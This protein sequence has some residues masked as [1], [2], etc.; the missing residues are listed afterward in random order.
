M[1]NKK[2]N[3]ILI[4]FII[5]LTSFILWIFFTLFLDNILENTMLKTK[6]Y[7][8]ETNLKEQE[9][10]N[11]SKYDKVYNII[12][13]YYY[14]ND[15]L[16]DDDLINWSINWLVDW[17]WDKHSD[18]LTPEEY[19]QFNDNLSWDFE[20]IGA[21]IEINPLW[22]EVDRILKGSPAKKNDLRSWDIIIKANEIE[23]TWMSLLEAVNNIKWPKW[24]NVEL[25]ILREWV[26]D[27]ITKNVTRDQIKIPSI[28]YELLD[29]NIGYVSINTFWEETFVDFQSALLELKDTNWLV[30]DLRDNWGWFLISAV[31]ILS[32]FVEKWNELVLTKYKDDTKNHSYKSNNYWYLYKWK[33]VVLINQNSASASEIVAWALS[34][35]NKAIIVWKKSYGKWSVQEPF[36]LEDD[37]MVKLTIAKW[38]TPKGLN[39]DKEWIEPDIEVWFLE[40]DYQNEYDRQKEKSIEVLKNFISKWN[41][42]LVISDYVSEKNEEK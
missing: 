9:W 26:D 30:I 1:N 40:E 4:V 37:S 33:V 8:I 14:D 21:V 32:K 42:D 34:D 12:R 35:Y 5:F 23:L 41:I 2:I 31:E 6:K 7:N 17:I 3:N 18:Y 24:T 20:W 15:K 13:N 29:D 16:T 25:S 39:I 38:F 22:V 19:K 27:I 28:D 10:I 36:I 11:L